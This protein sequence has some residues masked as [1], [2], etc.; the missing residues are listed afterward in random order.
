MS[1]EVEVIT[2]PKTRLF[3]TAG[4][5]DAEYQRVMA[6]LFRERSLLPA[7]RDDELLIIHLIKAYRELE[8]ATAELVA[9]ERTREEHR[10]EAYGPLAS[11]LPSP[12]GKGKKKT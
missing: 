12:K 1:Y 7:Y 11:D 5:T 9:A 4:V 8:E 10:A 3:V 6:D 2:A